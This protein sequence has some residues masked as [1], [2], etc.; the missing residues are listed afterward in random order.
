MVFAHGIEVFPTT[1]KFLGCPIPAK[2]LGNARKL[3]SSVRLATF[4]CQS[5]L[6]RSFAMTYRAAEPEQLS[7][8]P[9][10]HGTHEKLRCPE[11]SP[12]GGRQS[13]PT[14][15]ATSASTIPARRHPNPVARGSGFT[16]PVALFWMPRPSDFWQYHFIKSEGPFPLRQPRPR[17][18]RPDRRQ[19]RRL[20]APHNKN[21]HAEVWLGRFFAVFHPWFVDATGDSS[22]CGSSACGSRP[23]GSNACD[24]CDA[25]VP[26]LQFRP[27]LQPAAACRSRQT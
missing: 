10:P 26:P 11:T 15:N 18:L 6:S 4:D 17:L 8:A 5:G 2:A 3:K 9:N 22:A 13:C 14:S 21:A 20:S 24:T 23:C 16:L 19:L 1:L 12:S 7:H 25:Y 27:L